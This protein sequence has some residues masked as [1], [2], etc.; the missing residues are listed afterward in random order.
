MTDQLIS[1]ESIIRKAHANDEHF[2][3]IFFDMEK[4]NDLTWRYAIIRDLYHA[5]LRGRLSRFIV[6][7]LKESNFKV[8]V[9][10]VISENQSQEEGIPQG[11]VVSPSLFILRINKLAQLIPKHERFQMSLFMDD[12]KVSK[13]DPDMQ[14][15]GKKSSKLHKRS[16]KLC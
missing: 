15:I 13:R 14:N 2:V 16:T 5:G 8:Q 1:L 7:F 6:N 10:D 11:S 9:N 12:L 4:A 3:F